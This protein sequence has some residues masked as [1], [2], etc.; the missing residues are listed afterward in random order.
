[1]HIDEIREERAKLERSLTAMIGL[2]LKEFREKT[3]L[4]PNTIGVSMMTFQPVG[5]EPYRILTGVTVEVVL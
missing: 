2:R 3:G 4:S 5:G 1:M